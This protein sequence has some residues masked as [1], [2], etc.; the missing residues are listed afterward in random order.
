MGKSFLGT[1]IDK[2]IITNEVVGKIGEMKIENELNLV[3]L[4]GRKGKTLRNIY[5][6]TEDEGTSE[7]DAA[8]ITQEGIFVFES[9]NYSGWI[10]ENEKNQ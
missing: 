4:L 9:K 8:F 5:V 3:K 2:F 1:L 6:P 7:M 10:F